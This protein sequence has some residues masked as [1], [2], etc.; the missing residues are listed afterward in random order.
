VKMDPFIGRT[1]IYHKGFDVRLPVESTGKPFNATLKVT[2]QGCSEK[3]VT[4]CFP[5]AT[6]SFQISLRDGV[7]AAMAMTDGTAGARPAVPR[8][9]R[10]L[11]LAMLGAFAAGLLLT[12]TP[13]VLPM[14]P[15]VSGALVRTGDVTLGKLRGGLLS[16]TYVFGTAV[17]YTA[18]GVVAGSTGEQLQAYFQSPW[19]IGTFATILALLALSMFGLYEL[20]MPSFVQSKL[21]YHTHKIKGSGFIGAFILGIVSAL[22]V[23]ACV[24]PVLIS[25]LGAAIVA[26]DPVL[27]GAI[28]F[29]LAHGQGIVLVALGVGA[30]FLLPR[31]GVWMNKVKYVFGVMLLG[32]SIYL[33]G[34]IPQVPVLFLWA[35]L[36]IITGVFLGATESLPHGSTGWRYLWKGVGTV[37]L[38]WGVLALLGGM[39]GNRDVL[40]PVA[41]SGAT[42][43]AVAGAPTAGEEK[44]FER[45]TTVAALEKRLAEARTAGRPAL[46]DYYADWCAD[47]VRMEKTTFRDVRVRDALRRYVRLQVDVTE[48]GNP[49]GVAIKKRF[50]VF[51]PPAMLFFGAD[52]AEKNELRT[53][54]YRKAE[55][56]LAITGKI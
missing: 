27:G 48:A 16:Y 36:F 40:S 25:V 30:G 17:T 24:S 50:G 26:E 52:G 12:F 55:D 15:I 38:I 51:G 18:A 43:T 32:V 11:F 37:L 35:A 44:L 33:L 14:I 2:Y 29:A 28:M 54:G 5:P 46:L 3:G 56:F 10:A 21:H 23:G 8:D 20:Q 42:S 1:E 47:C 39:A 19:A 34:F 49:D 31:A 4:I 9:F 45:V 22:I 13:C 41:F 6:R 53:Y 7:L